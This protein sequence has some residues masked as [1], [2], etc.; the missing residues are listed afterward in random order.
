M[1]RGGKRRRGGRLH[2]RGRFVSEGGK[3]PRLRERGRRELGFFSSRTTGVAYM[4]YIAGYRLHYQTPSLVANGERC[5]S[6]FFFFLFFFLF[7]AS[8]IIHT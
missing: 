6:F 2:E 4:A 8:H 7:Y 5:F 1:W 3:I